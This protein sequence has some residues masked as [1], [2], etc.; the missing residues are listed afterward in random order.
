MRRVPH[1]IVVLL[2][3]SSTLNAQ[4]AINNDGSPPDNSAILDIKSTE[5]GVLLSRMNFNQRNAIPNPA[6]GLLIYCTDCRELQ[7][8]TGIE[9]VGITVGPALPPTVINPITGK[10]WMDRNLGAARVATS[11][12]DAL[13]VGDLYQWGRASDGHEK[14][15]SGTTATNATTAVPNLGN[16][17]DGL[18]ITEENFPQDWLTP[19]DN[20]LWDGVNGTN[21]PCPSGFRIATFAEWTAE[22]QSWTTNNSAGALASPLKLPRAGLRDID[23]AVDAG[24][25]SD[26]GSYWTSTNTTNFAI[27]LEFSLSSAGPTA[28][29]GHAGG[30]SIRCIKD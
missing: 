7:M 5:K 1:L 29:G 25:N 14:R 12:N 27:A 22:R 6:P 4:V 26:L 13:A 9:W 21:N 23:G 11:E 17:W 19:Q 30:R 10:I 8:Y 3:A 2:L 24:N 18:F 28:G 20:S 15:T 16:P